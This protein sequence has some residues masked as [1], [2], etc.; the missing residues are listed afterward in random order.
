MKELLFLRHAKSAWEWPVEDRNRPLAPKGINAITWVAHHWEARFK[1]FDAIYTSS[2][3]RALHTAAILA[4]EIEFKLLNFFVN[5][6]L[7]TFNAKAVISEVKALDDTMR[8]VIFVGNN[9]AFSLAADYFSATVV[10]ELK[11]A[12]WIHLNFSQTTWKEVKKGKAT[13]G[14]KKEALKKS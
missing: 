9:P 12:D 14:S 13:V 5:H 2:A 7:Y 3:I 8:K 10:P 6:N 4:H 11:T 1:S